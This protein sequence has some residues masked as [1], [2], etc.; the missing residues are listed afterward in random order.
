LLARITGR[1]DFPILYKITILVAPLVDHGDAVAFS[2]KKIEI[3]VPGKNV[4]NHPGNGLFLAAVGH[5]LVQRGFDGENL[6]HLL[7]LQ[8]DVPLVNVVAALCRS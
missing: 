6:G 2:R 8:H 7:T 5:S 3:D 1:Q 4:G